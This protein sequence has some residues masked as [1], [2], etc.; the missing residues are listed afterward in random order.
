[1]AG[2]V[3]AVVWKDEQN[4]GTLDTCLVG[5]SEKIKAEKVRTP[6]GGL[7]VASVSRP[8]PYLELRAI[9]LYSGCFQRHVKMPDCFSDTAVS[10]ID[11]NGRCIQHASLEVNLELDTLYS[12]LI[13]GQMSEDVFP[14]E[15][16]GLSRICTAQTHAV[17]PKITRDYIY[18]YCL[19]AEEKVH[20]GFLRLLQSIRG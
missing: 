10:V 17:E 19:I 7:P 13:S 18:Q 12:E 11:G 5:A 2:L 14:R 3:G 1:V 6:M 4:A 15:S 8:H 9:K 20:Y 16:N